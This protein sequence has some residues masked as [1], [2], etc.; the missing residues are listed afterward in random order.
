[1]PQQ[2]LHRPDIGATL[3]QVS[4]EGM[5]QRMGARFGNLSNAPDEAVHNSLEASRR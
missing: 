3:K 5:P 1:M 4:G 2:L